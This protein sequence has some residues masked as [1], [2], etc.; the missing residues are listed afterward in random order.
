MNNAFRLTLH[1]AFLG[2]EQGSVCLFSS[3]RFARFILSSG[4]RLQGLSW[5]VAQSHSSVFHAGVIGTGI[6]RPPEVKYCPAA[7]RQRATQQVIDAVRACCANSPDAAIS[8]ALL[9]VEL[10]SPD[11]MY[12]GLP[13]PE[14]DACK[15]TV[16]RDCTIRRTLERTPLLWELLWWVAWH[17]PALCYCSVLLRAATA[18]LIA[19]WGSLGGS[20]NGGS[21]V[22]TTTTVRLLSLLALSQLLPSPLAGLRDVVPHLK[23]SEVVQLLRDCVWSY[24][25]DHVPSPAL[26][27]RDA[28]GLMWRD[29]TLNQPVP[30]YSE[31]M[32]LIMQAN[33]S[34]L[35]PLYA[36]LFVP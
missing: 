21:V 3:V 13:W 32:R 29:P 28:S 26:F 10:V 31:T 19:Q 34:R 11:V 20:G 17:R 4:S 15:A 36:Q 12:N 35:G 16:E 1:A 8:V 23:P 6:R 22:P 30:Q 14:E 33:V 7:V 9:L 25:R 27:T 18:T 24:M 2:T 5:V